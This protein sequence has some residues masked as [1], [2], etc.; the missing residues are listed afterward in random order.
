M[1]YHK[2]NASS[3][4]DIYVDTPLADTIRAEQEAKAGRQTP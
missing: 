3:D 2:I 1:Q 4:F